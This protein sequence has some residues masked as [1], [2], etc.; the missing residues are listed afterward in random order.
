MKL[1]TQALQAKQT[2]RATQAVQA[3]LKPVT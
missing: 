3:T 2:L 1:A